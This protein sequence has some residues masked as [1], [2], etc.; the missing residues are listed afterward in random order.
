MEKVADRRDALRNPRENKDQDGSDTY[1]QR[2]RGPEDDGQKRDG[3]D[4]LPLGGQARKWWEKNKKKKKEKSRSDFEILFHCFTR[5]NNRI[6]P[7]RH[8]RGS[9]NPVGAVREPP[10]PACTG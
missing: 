5:L 9:G 6:K 4:P 3:N 1:M 2:L 8:S 7:I 10:P